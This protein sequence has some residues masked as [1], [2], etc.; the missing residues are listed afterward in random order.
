MLKILYVC[1]HNRCRSIL[2]EALTNHCGKGLIQAF[3]AGS[4][5]SGEVHPLTL[6]HLRALGIPTQSLKSQSWDD[7]ENQEFDAIITVCDQAARE[8]C[9][10][11]LR[12]GLKIHWELP[13]PSRIQGSPE[14]IDQAFERVIDM[15]QKR[16]GQLCEVALLSHEARI[17]VLE[18]LEEQKE[19]GTL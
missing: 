11:V 12:N 13:D 8:S 18:N 16:V 6:K 5:P 19:Y 2:S 14:E 3:S 15:I 7:F 4:Q 10:L 17:Q 1:T 9:P